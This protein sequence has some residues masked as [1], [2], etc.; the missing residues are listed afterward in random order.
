MIQRSKD[1]W[2]IKNQVRPLDN[3][4]GKSIIWP[5]CGFLPRRWSQSCCQFFGFPFSNVVASLFQDQELLNKRNHER[6]WSASLCS[7]Y[8]GASFFQ[9]VC[10]K[11][12]FF[13][14]LFQQNIDFLIVNK[15]FWISKKT[16][17]YD[18]WWGTQWAF[19]FFS[20]LCEHKV[21]AIFVTQKSCCQLYRQQSI[22]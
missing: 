22:H 4:H 12:I 9:K 16:S 11:L 7:V 1:W 15:I 10:L 20:K 18:T 2:D 8:R 14:E 5:L 3:S 19:Q 17:P 13:K 21:F 6:L